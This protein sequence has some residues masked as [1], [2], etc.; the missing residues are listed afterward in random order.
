MPIIKTKRNKIIGIV[1]TTLILAVAVGVP[2]AVKHNRNIKL[3]NTNNAEFQSVEAENTNLQITESESE[4]QSEPQ[5][6]AP[7]IVTVEETNVPTPSYTVS[8][9][10]TTMY[11]TIVL[12]VRKGAGTE[13]DV[14][15][16]VAKNT[17]LKVTGKCSNGWYRIEYNGGEGYCS[18]KY[19]S[20][21]KVENTTK[22]TS[23][24]GTS[25]KKLFNNKLSESQNAQ[26][27]AVAQ[28]IAN[29]IPKDIEEHVKVQMA[30]SKVY[31]EYKNT[32][33]TMEGPYYSQAYGVF[34]A[35]EASCAGATRALGLVLTLIGIKW[36]HAHEGEFH[37][38]WCR[39][40]MNGELGYAD[41]SAGVCGYGSGYD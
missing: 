22:K 30:T 1:S 31:E 17:Q 39:V 14:L 11:P 18:G 16:S 33:Y 5:T 4:Y 40:W 9:C 7:E 32:R 19:L 6:D 29:S 8:D 25:S 26:A 20:S 15:G 36:E 34:I 35:K 23:T 28:E 41:A 37:H 10:D 13:Y 2:L 38:Q 24:N 27:L 21:A 12:N 3:E